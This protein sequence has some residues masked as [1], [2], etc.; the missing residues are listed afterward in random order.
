MSMP[1]RTRFGFHLI[2]ITDKRTAQGEVKVAH[3]MVKTS[4]AMSAD[5]SLKAAKKINEIYEKLHAGEKFEDIARQFSE[6]Q[7]TAKNGGVLPSFGTGRMVPEF[8]KAAFALKTTGEFSQPIKTSYGWHIIKLIEKKGIGSYEEVQAEL[9]QKVQ[10]DSRSE[11][12][13]ASMIAR[14]KSKYGFNENTKSKDEFLK[15][16]DSSIV[17]GK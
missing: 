10:K 16:I 9:K 1:V 6:D 2:K 4:A 5:D 14:I 11:L 8:E 12:S 17:E 3:I 13:K 7:S 15:T